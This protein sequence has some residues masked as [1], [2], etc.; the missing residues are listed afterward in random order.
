MKHGK[1]TSLFE[2]P[3]KMMSIPKYNEV[4]PTVLIAIF[5]PLFFGFMVGD[6]GYAIPFIIIGAYGLKFAK[7]VDWR[8]I[9]TVLFFGGI[10]AAI[11]GF[12]FFGEALGMHFIGENGDFTYTWEGLLG[13]HNMPEF[14]ESFLPYGHGIHKIGAEFVGFLLK[15]SVYVGVVHLTV[16]FLVAIY[17]KSVQYGFKHGFLEKG[18]PFLS[19]AGLVILCYAVATNLVTSSPLDEMT[20]YI[21]YGVGAASLVIGSIL[22]IREEG[23]MKVIVDLPDTFGIVLSYTRLVAIGMS[24]AGMALAFNY[25][26]I[27]MIAAGIGGIAGL[28]IG[29]ILFCVLQL[30]IW[31]LAILSG[32]LHAL[33][34]QLVEFMIRFY[35]G[36]GTE[37]TPLKIKHIKTISDNNVKEA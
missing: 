37:F 31:T 20:T 35:E 15:L 16:G 32:G 18:G 24:K 22:I 34:L 27:G 10:W 12:F 8:A 3:T 23:V 21:C 19:F 26:A 5:L 28:I 30:M 14:F 7:N 2:Y 9:A 29:F 36:D 6:I 33:R 4:D 25:I 13:L 17:N 1:V 11:F